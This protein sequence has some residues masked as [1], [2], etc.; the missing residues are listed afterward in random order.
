MR[1]ILLSLLLT[2]VNCERAINTH[3]RQFSSP[4]LTTAQTRIVQ[5]HPCLYYPCWH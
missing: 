4:L 3:A 2:N 5:P 1:Y